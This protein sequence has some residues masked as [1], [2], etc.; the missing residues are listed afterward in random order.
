MVKRV[1]NLEHFTAWRESKRVPCVGS[2]D[3]TSCASQMML[4]LAERLVQIWTTNVRKFAELRASRAKMDRAR[5]YLASPGCNG[6]LG[7]AQLKVLERKHWKHLADLR[8]NRRRAWKVLARLD[9]ELG[10]AQATDSVGFLSVRRAG[11]C[12]SVARWQPTRCWSRSGPN[13]VET[14]LS[15][16]GNTVNEPIFPREG[17]SRRGSRSQCATSLPMGLGVAGTEA[18][19]SGTIRF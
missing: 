3:A 19:D 4:H 7:R 14:A 16:C 2:G 12:A 9:A 17:R 6:T 10:S 13:T 11:R 8:A 1:H 15:A 18:S 5:A